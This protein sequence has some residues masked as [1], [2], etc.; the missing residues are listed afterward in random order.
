MFYLNVLNTPQTLNT[1]DVDNIL[2]RYARPKG[3]AKT[4]R[5][6]ED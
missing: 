2:D 4:K 5:S 6:A 1:H 3:R